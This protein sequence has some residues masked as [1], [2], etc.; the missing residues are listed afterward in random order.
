MSIT[1][2]SLKHQHS[3]QQILKD[4]HSQ[5]Q[6]CLPHSINWKK[7]RENFW[8][9]CHYYH[10][11]W[12]KINSH[13]H[14]PDFP[15]KKTSNAISFNAVIYHNNMSIIVKIKTVYTSIRHTTLDIYQDNDDFNKTDCIYIYICRACSLGNFSTDLFNSLRIAWNKL[16]LWQIVT[17]N[18]I[19]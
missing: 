11:K 14:I 6:L 3:H 2:N 5:I 18:I 7:S 16:K 1:N 15:Q 19:L 12:H 9:L 8:Q 17:R 10:Q 4:I 13:M